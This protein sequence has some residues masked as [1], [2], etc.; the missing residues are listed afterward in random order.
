[1]TTF[2]II[3]GFAKW[4]FIFLSFLFLIFQN[5]LKDDTSCYERELSKFSSQSIMLKYN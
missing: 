3:L 2:F 5:H 1:L 4:F